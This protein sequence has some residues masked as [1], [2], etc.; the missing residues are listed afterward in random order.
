MYPASTV[1]EFMFKAGV[2]HQLDKLDRKLVGLI[3]VMSWVAPEWILPFVPLTTLSSGEK[4]MEISLKRI[5]R[6]LSVLIFKF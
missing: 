5:L 1:N 6:Q 3:P 4:M 2:Q